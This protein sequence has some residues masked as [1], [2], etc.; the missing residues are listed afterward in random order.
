MT[1]R[2]R[3]Q[4]RSFGRDVVDAFARSVRELCAARVWEVM[5]PLE[6]LVVDV[7][8]LG[9]GSLLYG[10]R[11]GA[12]T[13][14][15]LTYLGA[16]LSKGP[17]GRRDRRLAALLVQFVA[18]AADA[19]EFERVRG[20]SDCVVG[21]DEYVAW[22]S[23]IDRDERESSFEERHLE[24]LARCGSALAD[25]CVRMPHELGE[26]GS[27]ELSESFTDDEGIEYVLSS[28][29]DDDDSSSEPGG[30][31]TRVAQQPPPVLDVAGMQ[32]AF[33]EEFGSAVARS[34]RHGRNDPC[35]CG[36][37]RKYKKC[38]LA[39]DEREAAEAKARARRAAEP[40][41][42]DDAGRLDAHM[43]VQLLEFARAELELDFTEVTARL[44]A[45]LMS[46]T[47]AAHWA[48]FCHHIEG[49]SPA[50]H[51]EERRAAQ[52][53]R[54]ERAWLAGRIAGWFSIFEVD[55]VEPGAAIDFVDLLTGRRVRVQE[56]TASQ[57]LGRRDVLLARIVEEDGHF[58]LDG[59]HER[60]LPPDLA[61]D[62]V[63]RAKGRLRRTGDV[64][65]GRLDDPDFSAYLVRR[66]EEEAR[67]DEARRR[68]PPRLQNTDGE[69]FVETRDYFTFPAGARERVVERLVALEHARRD[70]DDDDEH[71]V[72][73]FQKPGNRLNPH[74]ENT[75]I[76]R[77][78]V[79][80]DA[81]VLESNSVERADAL[82]A[83]VMAVL[84]ST[85]RGTQRSTTKLVEQLARSQNTPRAA[86]EEYKQVSLAEQQIVR[87]HYEKYYALWPDIQV[88]ALGNRTPREAMR[89]A[90]GRA[91]VETLV[92]QFENHDGRRAEWER[93]DFDRLRRVLGLPT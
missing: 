29:P 35:P 24:L 3:F 16:R 23:A 32:V 26:H 67:K 7:P 39:K 74:W 93:Y 25:L 80:R 8:A 77:A 36:S 22:V 66:W 4:E 20:A 91:A 6:P 78:L 62:L 28:L 43:L 63:R 57:M 69:D 68:V 89:T 86:H 14:V 88:P 47:L 81:L 59:A 31:P 55:A 30:S 87:E 2:L 41:A 38:C 1:A 10:V 61:A 18:R 42:R 60:V 58:E 83:R 15:A 70:H 13:G 73:S 82:K 11:R 17:D 76:G 90:A 92:K 85:L 46:S 48:V 9:L 40:T 72:V 65:I 5:D 45:P 52:L 71:I 34:E 12:I 64:P 53:S 37:G 21:D 44:R 19:E 49:R 54:R 56:R 51:F 33:E 79:S 75:I 50:R 84:E 27:G